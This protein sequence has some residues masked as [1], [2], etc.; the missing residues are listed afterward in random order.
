M[1]LHIINSS[2]ID[3][4]LRYE[5]TCNVNICEEDGEYSKRMATG[6]TLLNHSPSAGHL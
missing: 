2:P 4:K 3:Q 6:Q 5:S 1:N